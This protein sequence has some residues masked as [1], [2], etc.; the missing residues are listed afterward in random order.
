VL[1][2]TTKQA[3]EPIEVRIHEEHTVEAD[4]VRSDPNAPEIR[5]RAADKKNWEKVRRLEDE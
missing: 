1:D 2:Q 4:K 5:V 3:G